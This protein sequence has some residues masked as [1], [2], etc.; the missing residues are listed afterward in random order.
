MQPKMNK[1]K[2]S[3]KIEFL[4]Q[5]YL[6]NNRLKKKLLI[7]KPLEENFIFNYVDTDTD[8]QIDNKII[9]LP[10]IHLSEE[11]SNKDDFLLN[12]N[13]NNTDNLS[14]R[15]NI[16]FENNTESNIINLNETSIYLPFA[17]IGPKS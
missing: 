2:S 17:A 8:I 13:E 7:S 3:S 10:I 11:I 14:I 9:D 16:E 1:S 4:L 15:I 12:I 6:F 5:N